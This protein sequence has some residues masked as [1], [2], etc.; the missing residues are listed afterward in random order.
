MKSRIVTGTIIGLT[1]VAAFFVPVKQFFTVFAV[2]LGAIMTLEALK[3]TG[4]FR[5]THFAVLVMLFAVATPFLGAQADEKYLIRATVAFVLLYFLLMIVSH[6]TAN[7]KDAMTALGMV[8]YVGFSMVSWVRITLIRPSFTLIPGVATGNFFCA[9]VL[10][11]AWLTDVFAYFGGRFFGKHKLCPTLSPHKTVEGSVSGLIG[12]VVFSVVFAVVLQAVHGVKTSIVLF[13]LMGAGL[14]VV[15][16]CGDLFAS[17][18]KRTYDIKD[19]GSILPGHGGML[20]RFDSVLPVAPVIM[21]IVGSD[22]I[23]S[24]LVTV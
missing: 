8:L 2:I 7:A 14:S 16:Q 22:F 20:D 11:I 24:L 13:A 6:D 5:H 23:F 12:A 18:I 9:L 3:C 17:L 10:I 1:V 21:M 4:L 15:S 19:Y